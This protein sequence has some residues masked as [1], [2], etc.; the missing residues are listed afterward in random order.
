MEYK[1]GQLYNG[2]ILKSEEYVE[3][4]NSKARIF[5]HE[6]TGAKLLNMDNDDTN[7]VF[8]IGFKTPPSDSTGVMHILEHS[9]LCGSRKFPTKEPFVELVKG[10]LNTFLNA[11]T[12]PDKTIYPIASQNEKDFFNL[13]D[14]YLDAVFYPNIY[15]TKEILMQEGWHYDLEDKNEDLTYKGVVYNEMK[16][17]FSSPEGILLRRIQQTLFPDNTYY[18]ESGGDPKNIPDLTYDQFINT[19]KKY[20]H[21]SNS[22]IFLY[23]NGDLNKQLEFIN[24][25]YLSKFDKDEIDSDIKLQAPYSEMKEVNYSYSI[26][27]ED[28]ESEKTFLALN[29]VTGRS[30]DEEVYTHLNILEYLLLETEGAPLKK[31]L[32]DAEIGKDVFGSFDN[33]ILQPVFSIIVKNSEVSKKEEFKNIVYDTL[34]DIVKNGIDKKLIEGCINAFEF[35]LREADTGS[36]PKGLV[37]YMNA[38]DSW[39]YGGDPLVHIRYEKTLE[40]VKKALNTNYFEGLIEKYLLNNNHA[41][42]LVLKPEK[43]LAEKEDE[44]LKEKLKSYKESLSENELDQIVEDTKNLIIR[45]S[46]PDSPEVLETIPMLSIDDIDRGVDDLSICESKYEDIELLHYKS[47]TSNIAYLNFMFYAKC[48]KEEDIPYFSLLGNL[49]SK[50]DT[51]TYEYKELSNEILI[52]T[53]DLFFK[54]VVYSNDK[55]ITKFYPFIEAHIKVMDSKLDK[56]ID[57]LSD[58]IQNTLFEDRK[59]IREIIRELIS[60]IEMNLMQ[61]GHQVANSRLTSYFSPTASYLE[62]ISGYD[63]YVFL[64]NIEKNYDLEFENMKSKLYEL[65]KTIFNK[66]NLTIAITGEEKELNLLKENMKKVTSILSNEKLNNNEYK[67]TKDQKNEGLMTPA[68]VQYVA[69]GYNYRD[70]GYDY[71]GSMLVLKTILGYDYLWNKVRVKGGAYGAMSNINREG[72]M[73][74]VSY[75]DPNLDNTI[76]AY[77]EASNYLDTFD[78]SDREMTK[79]IIGTISNLDTPLMPYYKGIK[80]VSMYIRNITKADREKEREEVLNTKVSDIKGYSKVVSEAMKKDYLAVVGNEKEIKDN[81]DIFSNLVNVFK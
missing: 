77:D 26:S 17:A 54:N 6:K 10:S 45:Q 2:F 16:G 41:S 5:E 58:I 74:F 68:N 55:D 32:I 67:F 8:A 42:L 39:L 79:Y 51:K 66:N 49:L 28:E 57:I 59:R 53:G 36:Y 40:S 13:M 64:K 44:E 76:K 65:K 52:N 27:K 37:Y 78:V 24:D 23:G 7:K 3:E 19:H 47:F 60:R 21:P 63:Y 80:A 12:Y 38:M 25:N 22:Y 50:V 69:K 72:S 14:V 11:M 46:T 62:K 70:L 1:I 31:A 81:K 56:S 48:I 15:K 20:Y 73:I 71:S 33:G 35:K 34:N 61:S 43:G 18:N 29:F 30:T 75:R 4:I 9:V